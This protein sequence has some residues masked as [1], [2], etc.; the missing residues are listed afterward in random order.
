MTCPK[1]RIPWPRWASE[2]TPNPEHEHENYQAL[3]RWA[4]GILKCIPP[5]G[6]SALPYCDRDS[7]TITLASGSGGNDEDAIEIVLT[8]ESTIAVALTVGC[9]HDQPHILSGR[10]NVG[11]DYA[12]TPIAAAAEYDGNYYSTTTTHSAITLPAGT[13]MFNVSAQVVDGVT[14]GDVAVNFFLTA[15]VGAN[16]EDF[17][18]IHPS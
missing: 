18:F 6:G 16:T 4:S 3:E 11:S 15:I 8:T 5:G 2:S 7:I 14:N 9:T 10:V 13:H 1:L 12:P 17:C